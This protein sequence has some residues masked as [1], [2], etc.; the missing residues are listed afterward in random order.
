MPIPGS[1][2]DPDIVHEITKPVGN[3][4]RWDCR[5]PSLFRIV[6][7]NKMAGA[8]FFDKIKQKLGT[9]EIDKN[10]IQ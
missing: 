5:W 10:M 8:A 3:Y 4:S 9:K 2:G 7:N 1:N 6:L